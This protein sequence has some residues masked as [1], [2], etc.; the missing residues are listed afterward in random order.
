MAV[1]F[2]SDAEFEN[3]KFRNAEVLPVLRLH[4]ATLGKPHRNAQNTADNAVLVI[5]WTRG[6]GN[7]FLSKNYME[8]LFAPGKALDA[9]RYFLIFPDNIGHGRSSKPSDGL[10]AQFP[11]YSYQDMV[12]LQYRLL[13]D[14]LGITHLRAVLGMSMGGMN[15]WQWAED[16]PDFMDGVMPV[17]AMPIPVSGRNLVWRRIVID[18][19]QS[20]PEYR[21]GDYQTP[22]RGWLQIFPMMRMMADGIPH[23]QV[24]IPDVAAAERFIGDAQKEAK[25]TDANDILY[26][27]RSSSDYNPE[28]RLSSIKTT[29]YALNFSDDEVNPA[30]LRITEKLISRLP[31]GRFV[32]QP[33]TEQSFGHLTVTHPELWANHVAEFMQSLEAQ[34]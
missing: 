29:V 28:S 15:A 6:D 23:L 14:K 26:S 1:L 33:G 8:A 10:K 16:H 25:R 27:L 2:E 5:H 19:I 24:T 22:P 18:S 17:G 13:T 34:R 7:T 20:D 31:H 32:L 12:D 21:G 30:E 9:S 4:Y 3:Y 11:K